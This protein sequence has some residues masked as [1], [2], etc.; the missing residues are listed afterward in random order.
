MQSAT[1]SLKAATS[2]PHKERLI[3]KASKSISARLSA[4]SLAMMIA[5][6]SANAL[7]VGKLEGQIRDNNSQQP[8]AGA[9][10]TLKELNL[11]QQ[12]GRDGRFFFVGVQDGDYTLVVNYLGAMTSEHKISI[13]DKQTTLQDISLSSQDDV[14]HIRVVGQQGALS[15]S[16]N[17]QRGADNVLSVV[18]ADVLGNFP[19]SNI[20]ESLQRVPGLSIERDQGEGR[21][22]RV[23]GMAPDY[24]SV[25]MNGTRLP[26]P[27]SDRRAV[28]LDVVPS[29]LLQSVEV[30][31]T[32]TPDMDADALG[33][34]IEVKSLSAF[35]RDDT[36]LNLNAEASQDTLTDNTNPK[37]AASYSDIIAENLGIAIATS[38]YNR[39]FG[40]DNVETGGDWTFAE[41]SGFDD[42]ALTSIDTRDYEI[43]RE[44]LG[45]GVNFDY[46]PSD[47]TDLYL[48]TL[49]SEFDDTE[50]RNSAKTKWK[51]AQQA[52]AL[53]QGK[54]TRSLKSRTENQN[55]TSFVLGGQTRFD[56]W[57]F[58]YQASHSTA[59]AEKPRDIA[60]TDFVAKIDN[61]GFSNTQKPQI[62][63]PEDY[64]QNA[65]FE[66]DEIE[67]AASKAEDTINAVNVDLTRQLTLGDYSAEVKTGV[68]ANMRAMNSTIA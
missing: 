3:P 40:S 5:G 29:D 62:I 60:G 26:S 66:L 57:T 48:R 34:A 13:R 21:F 59:S 32:L 44:R 63:A 54:T 31:K 38:W 30:S 18:S 35:D 45:I 23:R 11:S 10:V 2:A 14:E 64:Y 33:G 65:N 6:F 4:L 19:D 25:S 37:L 17:R 36:Y 24:N 42:A 58:D 20:S 27:E 50:T 39:D 67:I 15:K 55:I 43:N 49:Y 22:V 68:K 47:D 56:R 8:L 53:S 16:M 28:A 61:T 9:T 1:S 52:D 51:S 41:D 12:A 7:A 46:R